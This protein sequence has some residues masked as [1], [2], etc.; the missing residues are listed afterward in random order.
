ME[1]L[2]QVVADAKEFLK[3]AGF[4]ATV[5]KAVKKEFLKHFSKDIMK[6]AWV[7]KTTI[8]QW[9]GNMGKS[10]DFPQGLYW[11]GQAGSKADA[12]AK[13]LALAMRTKGIDY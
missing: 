8:G 5:L 6:D 1:R 4:D 9:N 2:K 3:E 10:R 7:I 12:M 11:H 13:M